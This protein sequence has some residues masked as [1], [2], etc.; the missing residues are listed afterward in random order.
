MR[1]VGNHLMLTDDVL[2]V[3][4]Q[5][6][7]PDSSRRSNNLKCRQKSKWIVELKNFFQK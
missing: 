4:Y 3:N 6:R 7:L 5:F 1:K 2:S